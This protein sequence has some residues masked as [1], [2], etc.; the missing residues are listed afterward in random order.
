VGQNNKLIVE[1]RRG[2]GDL[3]MLGAELPE[4]LPESVVADVGSAHGALSG[5][6]GPVRIEWVHDGKRV[7]VVQLHRGAT[8]TLGDVVVPG[9]A[10]RWIEIAAQQPLKAIREALDGLPANTGVW[11][12]GDI[13]L[14][15]HIAD[16]VRKRGAPARLRRI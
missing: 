13:G 4:M 12:S 14:T 10:D 11:I 5:T 8:G 7:W 9:E 15:S 2:A 6:L 1:G 3:L 16:L